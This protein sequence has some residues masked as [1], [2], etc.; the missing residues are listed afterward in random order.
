MTH[1]CVENLTIIGS[2]YGLSPD[3][4]QAIIWNNAGI[5]LIGP[6]GTNFNEILAE[7]IT[8]PFKK[9][10]LNVSSAKWWLFC[11]GLNALTPVN[12]S[13][14]E[15]WSDVS[16]ALITPS[17]SSVQVFSA[18]C[19]VLFGVDF[20][21]EFIAM[22]SAEGIRKMAATNTTTTTSN[23]PIWTA[24]SFNSCKAPSHYL[25]QCSLSINWTLNWERIIVKF[26]SRYRDF[27]SRD[28][29]KDVVCKWS[30]I[31]FSVLTGQSPVYTK[32]LFY[33]HGLYSI[34]AL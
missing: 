11:F 17:V 23:E 28:A 2:D 20:V 33:W 10:Y 18:L 4:R 27:L 34:S 25:N 31:L 24:V 5:L 8:F 29:I 19:L 16:F 7:I 14:L 9:M 30:S 13:T 6:L 15:Y 32:G 26:E 3:R 12:S 21:L 22:R 1:I